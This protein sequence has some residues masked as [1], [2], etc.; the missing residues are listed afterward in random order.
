MLINRRL[1]SLFS[2]QVAMRPSTGITSSN[3]YPKKKH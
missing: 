3:G 2:N 1:P